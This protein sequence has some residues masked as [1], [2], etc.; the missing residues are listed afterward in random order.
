MYL[1]TLINMYSYIN[2]CVYVCVYIYIYIYI[3]APAWGRR[4]A[5]ERRPGAVNINYIS[6]N[7]NYQPN[8]KQ[9]KH[10]LTQTTTNLV[11]HTATKFLTTA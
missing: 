1:Y 3:H 6:I 10:M 11:G 7:I 4:G 2:T 8:D 5:R 9:H